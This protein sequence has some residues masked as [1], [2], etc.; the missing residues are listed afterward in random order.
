MGKAMFVSETQHTLDDK[1]RLVL[2][3]KLRKDFLNDFYALIDFDHCISLYS[4]EEYQKRA[5]PI[6][7]LSTFSSDARKLKRLFFGNS[8]RCKLDGNGR[9]LLPK[10]FLDKAHIDKEVILVGV[11]D[12]LELWDAKTYKDNELKDDDDYEA[13]AQKMSDE[14][15]RNG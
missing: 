11:W 9:L 3:A 1:G 10:V 2:P 7:S 5:E 15:K 6:M 4:E 12:H 8:M 13:L 14:G